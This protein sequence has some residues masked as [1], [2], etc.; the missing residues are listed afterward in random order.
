MSYF[1]CGDTFYLVIA[2]PFSTLVIFIFYDSHF[3]FAG[4]LCVCFFGHL[5]VVVYCCLGRRFYPCRDHKRNRNHLANDYR[6]VCCNIKLTIIIAKHFA[7]KVIK[8]GRR[9]K[10][11]LHWK[12]PP[13]NVSFLP[14]SFSDSPIVALA[15]V[16]SLKPTDCF[17]FLR[18]FLFWVF[19]YFNFVSLASIKDVLFSVD[20]WIIYTIN[21]LP[22]DS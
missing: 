2:L 9:H 17:L 7:G 8:S 11:V 19:K 22:P 20:F 4:V 1:V 12:R 14:S 13:R 16:H 10:F 5:C 15:L 18:L 21:F 6:N 3:L